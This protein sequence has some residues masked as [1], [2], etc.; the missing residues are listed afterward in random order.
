[1][2]ENILKNPGLQ[3][4]AENIFF[5]LD[6]EYLQ[7]FGLINQSSKQILDG[8]MFQDPMFWLKQFGRLSVKNQKDWVHV[9]HSVSN[10][11]QNLIYKWIQVVWDEAQYLENFQFLY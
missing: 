11:E 9:I 8:P 5:N 4:I 10:N 6:V 1:M 3:H 7:I 2:F